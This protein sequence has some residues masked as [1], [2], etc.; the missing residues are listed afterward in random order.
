V[1]RGDGRVIHDLDHRRPGPRDQRGAVAGTMRRTFTGTQV[2][3]GAAGLAETPGRCPGTG[4]PAD[5]GGG[6]DS[7][8]SPVVT[9]ALLRS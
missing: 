8:A 2:W 3:V 5:A 6:V 4:G 9:G 7:A 1:P